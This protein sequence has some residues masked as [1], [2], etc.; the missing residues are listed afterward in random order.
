MANQHYLHT[1]FE[2]KS[3]AVFGVSE[4]PNRIA[5]LVFNNIQEAGFKGDLFPLNP[6]YSKYAGK[7][8]YDSIRQI[9]A[10]VDLAVIATP[11]ATVPAILEACGEKGV[12]NAIILS[13]GFSETGLEG[14]LLEEKLLDIARQYD[15]R[16]IGP[17][18]L[19]VI[20]PQ[21]GLNATFAKGKVAP[22][23]IALISQSGAIC[24][25][26]LDWAAS[27][28][29]GFSNVVSLGSSVD[30]D[31]GE[32]LDYLVADAKTTSILMYIEG[33]R[34]AR[35]FMSGLRAAARVKPIVVLKAGRNQSGSKAVILHTGVMVG[36]DAVFD[37]ALRRAGVV[38][39]MDIVDLFAAATM[40]STGVRT[41]GDSLSIITNGG[42]PAI[43]ACD[44][45][46]DLHIP[47]ARL[48][49][50]TKQKLNKVLPVMWSR[51]NPVDILGDADES[52]Y[53]QACQI[54]M[55][56]KSSDGVLVLLTPQAMTSP[57][58][59]AQSIVNIKKQ[60][61]NKPLLTCWLGE[62]QVSEARRL[63]LKESVPTFRLPENAVKS[64][65]FLSNFL[66]NQKLLL[67]TPGPL[68]AAMHPD[69]DQAKGIIENAL[70]EKR[71][72]L[73]ESETHAILAAF[74]IPVANGDLP[75]EN[76][77][78]VL[79]GIVRDKVFGPVINFGSGG[80]LAE[81]IADKAIAL[82]P[83]N[84]TLARELVSQTKIEKLLGNY[85][86]RLAINM[87]A[88]E[89]VLLR[90]SEIAC[91]LP[92]IRELEINPLHVDPQGVFAVSAR[93]VVDRRFS[94]TEQ[95]SH[96]AI[97]PYPSNLVTYTELNDGLTCVIRPIR[98]EDAEIKR[99][100]VDRMSD[101]SKR[102]RF[103]NTFK[104]ISPEMLTRFTQI[105]YDREMALIAVVNTSDG[106]IEIGV[107]RYIINIDGESC[108][109]AI[110]VDEKWSGKGVAYKLMHALEDAARSRGLVTIVGDVLANNYRMQKFAKN[111]GFTVKR[112]E[113][114]IDLLRIFKPL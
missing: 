18:C 50:E 60:Y 114:D 24:T 25:A 92:N 8:C 22:G 63:F 107:A 26:I 46:S 28:D 90:I 78:E 21:K 69:I 40:L 54:M 74:H 91:E 79:V 59:I 71:S 3:I 43:M 68:S 37:A 34:D 75:K 13:A 105:D 104:H 48:T 95:Y 111:I 88:L 27:R 56:D 65:A 87:F 110:A 67:Q 33:I 7:K 98:P 83:L 23:N 2:P 45:A 73:H 102:L 4:K 61:R 30:V 99:A 112:H 89:N 80:E 19:G 11:A 1:L 62:E 58:K 84:R 100:F 51:N 5:S 12:K 39:G 70:K 29:I 47:L 32:I 97:H 101:E 103:M 31:F 113:D 82:P 81:L 35:T 96:T 64:Y 52:R 55:E 38:R 72:V 109:F 94:N 108:E 86:N 14:A 16:F 9:E 93:I 53:E 10:L 106:E 17:N 66:R 20:R 77:R 49:S 15:I 85:R 36:D 57:T 41:S 42:G 6:K 44:K 76:A